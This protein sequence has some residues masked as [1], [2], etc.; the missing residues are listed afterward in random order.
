LNFKLFPYTEIDGIRTISDSDMKRLFDRTVNDGSDKIVFYEGTILTSDEFLTAM[1]S[2]QVLFYV[3][4]LGA[5]IVGYTWLNRFENHTARNHFCGFSEVWGQSVVLGRKAIS[6]LIRMKDRS[7]H[8]IFDLF[9]G[10]IPVW[11]KLAIDFA[12]N[13]G[14]QTHGVIPNAIWNQEKQKSEDAVFIYYTRGDA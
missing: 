7:G 14:A 11:N 10:F 5:D 9:T 4:Y 2:P 13:C 3:L 8:Y 6:Q 12:L 1:K